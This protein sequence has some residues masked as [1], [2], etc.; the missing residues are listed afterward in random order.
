LYIGT[1][2]ETRCDVEE[3]SLGTQVF[4]VRGE[5]EGDK[6]VGRRGRTEGVEIQDIVGVTG[7]FYNNEDAGFGWAL[8]LWGRARRTRRKRKRFVFIAGIHEST[9][10]TQ[11]QSSELEKRIVKPG[12]MGSQLRQQGSGECGYALSED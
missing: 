5:K 1:D 11:L 7:R 10:Q 4:W 2:R 9:I 6:R 12:D 3:K 8:Q